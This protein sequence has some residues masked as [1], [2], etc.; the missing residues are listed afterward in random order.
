L[1][2]DQKERV[3]GCN[4]REDHARA[5]LCRPLLFFAFALVLSLSAMPGPA[6]AGTGA[7]ALRNPG[8]EFPARDGFDPCDQRVYG[9]VSVAEGWTAYFFCKQPGD[10]APINRRPE[11]R[12]ADPAFPNRIRSGQTALKYF[13][14]WALNRSTG[15]FQRVTGTTPGQTYRFAMWVQIWTSNCD[16]L[17]PSSQ[18]EPGNL[19]ARVCIDRDGGE[20]GP[21]SPNDPNV[22]C[23]DWNRQNVWDKYAKIFVDATALGPEITVALNTRAEWPVKHNDLY[24]DDATLE[25]IGLP[26]GV[27][28]SPVV[29][30]PMIYGP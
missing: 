13:N 22:V 27:V 12:P 23:G 1:K 9:D 11:F 29:R 28:V 7:P 24:G 4:A 6:Q 2:T 15:V 19:E 26:P 25:A 30:L 17:V 18:C 3:I 8:F 5:A 21:N 20:F 16:L 14:F 10:P